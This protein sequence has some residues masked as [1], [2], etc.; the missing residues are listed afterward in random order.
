MSKKKTTE[1]FIIESKKIFKD[2]YDYI[3][4]NYKTNHDKVKIICSLHG[5]FEIRPNDHLSKKIGCQKCYNAGISKS[6]NTGKRIINDFITIHG[7]TYDYSLVEY[8]GTDNK[9][10]I[11]CKEHGVFEQT[12]HHH[13]NGIGCPKCANVRKL[14]NEEFILKSKKIHGD[15]YDYSLVKYENYTSKVKI[16]CLIHGIFELIPHY[17]LHK[18]TGCPLCKESK[19]EK[20]IRMLLDEK[21]IKYISQKRFKD[22]RDI[23][24]LPFDFYLPDLNMCIEYDGVQHF[25]V[26]PIFGG[27]IKLID[28][29]RKDKLKNEF[30]LN[31]NI[32]LFRIKYDDI[33]LEKLKEII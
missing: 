24:P 28:T 33:I 27:G 19:G 5:V 4:T 14:T 16:N 21:Q 23:N 31:N 11:V 25:I 30:C 3:L 8:S 20:L 17:H 15:K 22:C 7:D 2:K 26:V 13:R 6:L 32:K 18:K 29:Q 10:K 9:I 1:E 12:P